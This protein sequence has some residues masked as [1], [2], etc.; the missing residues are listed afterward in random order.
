MDAM[1]V[2]LSLLTLGIII[3][4]VCS[5]GAVKIYKW[6][7]KNRV[8]HVVDDPE[9]VPTEYRRSADII[10][11]ESGSL[12]AEVNNLLAKVKSVRTALY[13]LAG[14][15]VLIFSITKLHSSFRTTRKISDRVKYINA[16][17]LSG[18]E[19]MDSPELR[20]FVMGLLKHRGFTIII[21]AESLNP[22][23]DFIAEK[24]DSKYA[25]QIYNQNHNISRVIVNDLD[26]E[27]AHFECNRSMIISK[28]YC[29]DDA[30][31][32]AARAAC[33]LADKD[34]LAKWIYDF[35][36]KP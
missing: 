2:A 4:I 22:A 33:T 11:E 24:E 32:L 6:T 7:D 26:R 19:R 20:R 23:V 17:E 34:T 13:A 10:D 21:P 16:Y 1:R 31:A 29:D 35:H 28:R 8:V 18:I 27:K 15:L 36:A 9:K 3:G 25:V 12:E 14:M 5:A 30:R